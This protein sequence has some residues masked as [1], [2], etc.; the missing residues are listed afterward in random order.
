MT[1]ASR[2][3]TLLLEIRWAARLR[4]GSLRD[5]LWRCLGPRAPLTRRP[6]TDREGIESRL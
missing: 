4:G 3:S 5:F 6:S 1:L 2:Q